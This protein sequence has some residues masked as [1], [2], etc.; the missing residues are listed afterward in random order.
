M[1]HAGWVPFED[2]Y[3]EQ[4]GDWYRRQMLGMLNHAAIAL[5]VTFAGEPRFGWRDRSVGVSVVDDDYRDAGWL[6]LV[7]EAADRDV[8]RFWDGNATASAA[9]CA[10]RTPRVWRSW[11]FDESATR[12]HADVM[13]YVDEAV[14]SASAALVGMPALSE[15]WWAW[16]PGV[17]SALELAE[18]GRYAVDFDQFADRVRIWD[19]YLPVTVERWVPA[20]GDLHWG[21][22]TT[23]SCWWLDWEG[24]GLAPEGFD[25]ASLYLHSLAVPQMAE[26]IRL[27]YAKQLDS[28]DGMFSQLYLANRM[29]ARGDCDDHPCG[30]ALYPH[31]GTLLDALDASPDAYA[32]FRSPAH[33][34]Q[35]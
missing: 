3:P 19:K 20:H 25:V 8:T 7:A 18:T 16:L 15:T 35:P 33:G 2:Y 17:L 21:Q 32:M 24:W 30:Q 10:M 6:R 9:R 11:S 31:V 28:R 29:L 4:D 5:R 27:R 12:Y 13:D 22:L 14:C 26:Q 1:K 34:P 23:A